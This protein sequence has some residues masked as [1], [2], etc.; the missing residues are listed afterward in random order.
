[1]LCVYIYVKCYTHTRGT[2][3]PIMKNWVHNRS[4]LSFLA[5]IDLNAWIILFILLF[6]YYNFLAIPCELKLTFLRNL[7]SM[8]SSKILFLRFLVVQCWTFSLQ[9][10]CTLSSLWFLERG[11]SLGQLRTK[12]SASTFFQNLFVLKKQPINALVS[13]CCFRH[14]SDSHTFTLNCS[15]LFWL[16]KSYKWADWMDWMNGLDPLRSLVPLEHLRC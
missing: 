7:L 4:S 8:Q 14:A 13:E 1:M 2:R 9:E 3:R 15:D 11:R 6:I 10:S 12:R 16:F 5:K